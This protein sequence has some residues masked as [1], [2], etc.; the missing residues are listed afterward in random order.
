[1][2]QITSAPALAVST[3]FLGTQISSQM[4]TLQISP[5]KAGKFDIK[6]AKDGVFR[7]ANEIL[8]QKGVGTLINR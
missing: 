6:I 8:T 2:L 7:S 4:S 1:M 5:S 3:A